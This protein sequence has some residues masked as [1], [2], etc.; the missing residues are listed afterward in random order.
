MPSGDKN[1]LIFESMKWVFLIVT[2]L[3]SCTRLL[4]CQSFDFEIH[5][6]KNLSSVANI[7]DSV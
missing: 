1:A 7:S 5:F 3:M 2:L 6:I 4:N